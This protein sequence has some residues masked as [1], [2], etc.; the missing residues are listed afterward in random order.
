MGQKLGGKFKPCSSIF[1]PPSTKSRQILGIYWPHII[2]NG[3]LWRFKEQG[4]NETTI[5]QRRWKWIDHSLRKERD[6]TTTPR[7]SRILR[8]GGQKEDQS[9]RGLAR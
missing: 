6:N 7:S 1:R 2:T 4:K 8:K 9:R 5:E 3:K